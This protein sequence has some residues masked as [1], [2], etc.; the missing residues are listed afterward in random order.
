M[1]ELQCTL[2]LFIILA[3]LGCM[4]GFVNVIGCVLDSDC[5]ITSFLSAD[6]NFNL[7]LSVFRRSQCLDDLFFSET[8]L[9]RLVII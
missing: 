6:H 4:F 8:N 9:A 2:C 1:L 5:T 7:F 3:Y